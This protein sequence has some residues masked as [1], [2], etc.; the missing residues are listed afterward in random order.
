M[1]N[2]TRRNIIL[3]T[4]LIHHRELLL[5]PNYLTVMIR[6]YFR[7]RD[8]D[9]AETPGAIHREGEVCEGKV[10]PVGREG[11]A[12]VDRD[13][14]GF[15]EMKSIQKILEVIES[16]MMIKKILQEMI[17]DSVRQSEANVEML[18]EFS[19]NQDRRMRKEEALRTKN[20]SKQS[21]KKV[22]LVGRYWKS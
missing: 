12:D 7:C 18:L 15:L 6:D 17:R 21:G 3:I 22:S 10:A 11:A 14:E 4:N 5:L 9:E 2:Y 16:E 1:I 13:K 19:Y 8:R 20:C